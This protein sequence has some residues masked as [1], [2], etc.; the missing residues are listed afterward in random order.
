MGKKRRKSKPEN[1]QEGIP[2]T[3]RLNCGSELKGMYCHVCGQKATS[4][5]P[6][7][8]GFVG[9]PEQCIHMGFKVFSGHYRHRSPDLVI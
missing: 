7:I 1:I 9:I 3:N 6:T 2:Y 8:L 4:K 5:T